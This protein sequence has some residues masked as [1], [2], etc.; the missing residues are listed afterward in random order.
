ML[1]DNLLELGVELR[2]HLAL[3]DLGEEVLLRRADVLHDCAGRDSCRS[4]RLRC[5]EL[6]AGA[7]TVLLPSANLLDGDTV[8]ETVDTL[9]DRCEVSFPCVCGGDGHGER[10]DVRRRG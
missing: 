8:E 5:K 9:W 4:V 1:L 10:R 3:V 2:G 7:L 6:A